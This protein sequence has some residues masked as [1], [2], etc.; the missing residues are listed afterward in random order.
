MA[1]TGPRDRS[2]DARRQALRAL[3]LLLALLAFLAELGTARIAESQ[4]AS[5]GPGNAIGATPRIRPAPELGPLLGRRLTRIEVAF[6]G[7]RWND[8]VTLR[9]V[10]VGDALTPELA[11]RALRELS[12]SGRYANVRAEAHADGAG[13][14][15]RLVVLPR[16]LI[17]GV[18]LTGAAVDA[19]ETLR[20]SGLREGAEIT[21]PDVAKI[22]ERLRKFH[23][24][25]G[26]PRAVARVG[27]TDTDDPMRVLLLIDITAGKPLLIGRRLFGVWPDP[28]LEGLRD[29]LGGYDVEEEDPA[30]EEAL[31][32]ADRALEK[33]LRERGW[34][35]AIVGH[36]IERPERGDATLHV[37]V[38][39]GP[40]IL[41]RFEGNRHFDAS[42]LEDAFESESSEDRAPA[43]LVERLRGYYA[44]RG[45]HDVEIDVEERGAKNAPIH[46]LVFSIRESAPL[47]VV[48]REYPCLSGG[49]TAADVG[50]EI[51]SFLSEELPGADFLNSVDP[52]R[53]DESFGPRHTTGARPAP[54]EL[55][56]WKTYVPEVYD[57][58]MKHLQDLYRSEGYLSATVGPLQLLRRRCHPRSPP[59]HCLPIGPRLRPPTLCRYDEIGLPLEEPAAVSTLACVPDPGAGVRCEPNAILH[60]P[61][62]LG[63]RTFLYDLAFEGNRVLVERALEE[64]AELELGDPVSQIELEKARRRVLDA[65]AEEGFAFA[66]LET[67]LDLSPDR[68]RGRVRFVISERE[69]VRVSGIVIRGARRTSESL[70]RSRVA[71][72][73]GELYRRS[74]VRRTEELLATLGVFSTITIGFEDPYIP[75]RE[76]VVVITVVERRPQYLDVRPGFSTGEGFRVSFEYGHRNLVGEAIQL[77]LRSQL[78][79]LP[80]AFIIEEDVRQKYDELEVGERLERRNTATVEFPE[81]GLGPLFRLSVEG[82]DVRDNARDFGLTKDA[83]ILTLTFRPDR[84]FSIQVGGSLELNDATIFGNDQKGALQEYVQNNPGQA[85]TFRVPEGTTFAI[86]Q[87]LGVTWDRR[88]NP[89]GATSGTLISAGVEHVHAVPVGADA[90]AAADPEDLFA[91]TTSDFLRWTN[92]LAGYL[93][94]SEKGLALAMSFRWG[95]NQQLIADSRTYPDR[96]FFMGGVDS[97]RGY[98]QDSLV[99]QD[100]A[101]ELLRPGS[102]LTLREVVIRGGDVFV[103]PRAE[104]RIPISTSVQTALFIDAGNLWTDPALVEPFNLRYAAGTG[105]RIATPIGPLVFDYGFNIDRVLD[106]LDS[107]RANQRFWEDL[108]AFHFSIGLF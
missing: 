20:A 100:I 102:T 56:P 47:R 64:A 57:R 87:R 95:Y 99:P 23:A 52:A 43:T 28:K 35:R 36:R 45:F 59:G 53:V 7:G 10:Q 30:D 38:R 75:A 17:T 32:T 66:E 18:R 84:R 13:A 27:V 74:L 80:T 96:L 31:E 39:A 79:Y 67:E 34:Q 70:I 21:A 46:E 82:V 73:V 42:Q 83:G 68:T 107:N 91:A 51:D 85:G 49:R 6:E 61:I 16:R 12:D 11:R 48:A 9:R 54:Y 93:R 81:I 22:A 62:K 71:L 29:V 44:K 92:R 1:G 89:L 72:E 15:L 60:L 98:S 50:A 63:P 69:Q 78:G 40:L 26:Y 90:E 58:A 5:E 37:L 2:A 33:A 86:A 19:E 41:L 104:L 55:N 101:E 14:L 3:R 97:L 94:F 88:D 65:Y 108:G 105:I 8:R 77:T 106:K 25:R 24:R 103:N 76:K 4:P